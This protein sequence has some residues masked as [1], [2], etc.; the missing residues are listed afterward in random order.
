MIPVKF[1]VLSSLESKKLRSF[2]VPV[3]SFP[4]RENWVFFYKKSEFLILDCLIYITFITLDSLCG[5]VVRVLGYRSGG[6][7]SIPDTTKKK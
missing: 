3:I 4:I 5:L 7:G 6:P 2:Y 1:N